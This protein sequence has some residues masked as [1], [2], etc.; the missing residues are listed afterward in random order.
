MPEPAP[1]IVLT[2]AALRVIGA[3]LPAGRLA[4]EFAAAR[5][6]WG[7]GEITPVDVRATLDVL[8]AAQVDP[9][10]VVAADALAEVIEQY[11]NAMSRLMPM[12]AMVGVHVWDIRRDGPEPALMI[13]RLPELPAGAQWAI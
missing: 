2:D 11:R 9:W 12:A 1:Y 6:S 10:C 5:N 3:I 4:R 8:I 13:S 7:G